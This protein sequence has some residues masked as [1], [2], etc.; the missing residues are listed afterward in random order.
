LN[1][2]SRSILGSAFLKNVYTIF[3]YPDENRTNKDTW[4]PTVGMI[5]LTNASEA[6]IDFY[7]VRFLHQSLSSVSAAQKSISP[8]TSSSA[9]STPSVSSGNTSTAVGHKIV[10][11]AIIAS[12]STVGFFAVAA[13]AFYAWW[14][15]LRRKFGASGVVEYAAGPERRP[16][17]G[18]ESDMSSSTLRNRK[19]D[20]MQRQK[21]MIEGYS[22]YERDS[23]LS[24]T[25]G[26]DSIRLGYMPELL[27][28][29]EG[30]K[31]RAADRSS[32]GS[33]FRHSSVDPAEERTAHL[34]DIS[35]YE[36]AQPTDLAPVIAARPP[37]DRR[38]VSLSAARS[39]SFAS[40]A[41]AENGTPPTRSQGGAYPQP[42]VPTS[43]NARSLSLAM[44]GPFPSSGSRQSLHRPDASPLY[45]IRANDYF[46]VGPIV[47][48]QPAGRGR[49]FQRVSCGN[50]E[51]REGS[52]SRGRRSSPHTP[53]GIISSTVVEEPTRISPCL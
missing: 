29:D 37:P 49:E 43:T 39:I 32:V 53:G 33:T 1:I 45:D 10:S 8:V 31:S 36:P 24:T 16:S 19:H 34:M 13:A 25:E 51:A 23:W 46:T 7:A 47:S 11:T 52:S 22:D 6:S 27:E 18:R 41:S 17:K 9:P 50:V 4:Q 44:A 38:G 30:R 40:P 42:H 35:D 15:W 5:S 20:N 21:S 3:Q 12:V 48:G 28:E 26:G 2:D 14:F